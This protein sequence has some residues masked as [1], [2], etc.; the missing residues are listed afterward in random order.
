[1]KFLAFAAALRQGSFNRKL[2]R[3]VIDRIR[4]HGVEVDAADF[5]EFDMP[6]YDGDIEAATG[7]PPGG[8][9][10][11]ARIGAADG[12]II[13]SP[14]YNLSIPG[15]LKNAIDWISRCKPVPLRGKSALLVS[16]SP[17]LV[18]GNRGLWA[19]RPSLE[20]LGT[21][22][23]PDMFSLAQADQAFDENGQLKDPQMT[24]RLDRIIAGF[25]TTATALRKG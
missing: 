14:E 2:I 8:Q 9:A 20:V 18:G 7:V 6:L 12:L 16:A 1:M 17:S 15:T 3:V 25:V 24:K 21:H 10:L 19:L 11:A 23:Y 5:R 22:I 13:S 4:T